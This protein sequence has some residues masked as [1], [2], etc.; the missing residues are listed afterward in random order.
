MGN[1][2]CMYYPLFSFSRS[3]ENSIAK[4]S[5]LEPLPFEIC[6]EQNFCNS[7]I[8]RA[9][10]YNRSLQDLSLSDGEL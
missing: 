8:V 4:V 6:W 9:D 3:M 5:K 2:V 7:F 10:L 1:G